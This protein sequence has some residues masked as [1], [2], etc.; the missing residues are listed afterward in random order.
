MYKIWRT[1]TDDAQSIKQVRRIFDVNEKCLFP[2]LRFLCKLLPGKVVTSGMGIPYHNPR[3]EDEIFPLTTHE[4]EGYEFPVPGK[5][6]AHLR[7]IYG[8]Y[9]QLPDL[10]KLTPHVAQLEMW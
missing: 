1:S 2:L 6:D 3:F 8:D 5:A 9:M 10:N 4:F 7:H